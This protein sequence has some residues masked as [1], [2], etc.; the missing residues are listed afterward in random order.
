MEEGN[1]GWAKS[2]KLVM[3]TLKRLEECYI[4]QQKLIQTIQVEI[5]MLK[6]KSS[7]FGGIAGLIPSLGVLVWYLI[8]EMKG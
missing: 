1:N 5:A 7:L 6:L 3:S 8:K 2:A 4:E